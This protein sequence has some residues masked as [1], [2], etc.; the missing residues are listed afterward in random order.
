MPVK[1]KGGRAEKDQPI[2]W[3]LAARP[4]LLND[5]PTARVGIVLSPYTAENPPRSGARRTAGVLV[6]VEGEHPIGVDTG[7]DRP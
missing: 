3:H 7:V 4:T 2:S 1:T 5:Q 6:H